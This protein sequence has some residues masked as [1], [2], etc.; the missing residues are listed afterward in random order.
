MVTDGR[1]TGAGSKKDLECFFPIINIIRCVL[2]V[3]DPYS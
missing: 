2:C 3:S 1:R